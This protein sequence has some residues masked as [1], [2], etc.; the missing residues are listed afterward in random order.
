MLS[1]LILISFVQLWFIFAQN[2][3]FCAVRQSFVKAAVV[4]AAFIAFSTEIFSFLEA[5]NSTNISFL[6]L[7]ANVC[8]SGCIFYFTPREEIFSALK[9]AFQ[10]KTELVA[11]L[12]N[13][14]YLALIGLIYS[15]VLVVALLSP[16]NTSDSMSYHLARVANWIQQSSVEFYPTAVLRQLYQNPL[17]EYAI[18]HLQLLSGNDYYANLVQFFC[19]AAVGITASLLA[20]EC[21]QS[22]KTQIIAA[23]LTAT[24]PM[25][26]LQASGTQNDLVV[27]LFVLTFLYFYLKAVKSG[28]WS[29]FF[30]A[31]LSLGAALLSKGTGYVFC[32]P[33]GAF[34]FFGYFFAHKTTAARLRFVRQTVA[35]VLLAVAFN[36][37]QYSRNYQLFGAPLSTGEDKVTNRNISSSMVI[38]NVVRNYALHLGTHSDAANDFLTESAA[39]TLGSE[40]ANPD[41]TYLKIP[42]SVQYS[43]NE[44]SAGNVAH[45]ILLTICLLASLFYRGDERK[46]I[47]IISL[48]IVAGFL[49]FCSLLMWQPWASRL[50]LPLFM[51]GSI[52]IAVILSRLSSRIIEISL[53][54]CFVGS[55]LVLCI[56]QPRSVASALT[57]PRSTQ[58]FS[59]EP[60]LAA[61]Y[62]EAAEF[63]GKTDAGEIGINLEIDY[64]KNKFDDWEYPLWILIKNKFDEKPRFRHIGVKNVS[65]RLS[66]DSPPPEWIF[67]TG[68][69]DVFENIRYEKVWSKDQFRILRKMPDVSA[70]TH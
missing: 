2:G 43:E 11:P 56:G 22:V 42:F 39:D 45:I 19:F 41:S 63:F 64:E 1:C 65:S 13:K 9:K 49:L 20:Q 14:T 31:G 52:P 8:L 48:S 32:F 27:A 69:Q 50:H 18:L 62:V 30:F 23:F 16:P 5:L 61:A 58:Y 37:A 44:D 25:A 59:A 4:V 46:P 54:F 67:S 21:G 3:R 12:E 68:T 47:V 29:D 70:P 10:S 55:L 60:L 38:S 34:L 57:I 6:W 35:V 66:D 40:I 53:L 26:I 36:T 51:L 28:D 24:V 17:A 33:I 7:G 15:C